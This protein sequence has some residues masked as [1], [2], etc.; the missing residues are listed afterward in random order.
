M[1]DFTEAFDE[2]IAVQ[3]ATVGAKTAVIAGETVS[4]FLEEAQYDEIVVAGGEGEAGGFSI[5]VKESA[6]T[7]RPAHLSSIVVAGRT[8]SLLLLES[9]N[10]VYTI[11]AGDPVA[12][13]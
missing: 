1:S 4:V 12:I 8:L 5:M 6:L 11:T 2:L 7:A 13:E 3:V 10:G 9:A